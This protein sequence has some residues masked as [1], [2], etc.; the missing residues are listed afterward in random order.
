MRFRGGVS[1]GVLEGSGLRVYIT[2][3]IWSIRFKFRVPF[4]GC[5]FQ[6][7]KFRVQASGF[8]VQ[9]SRFQSGCYNTDPETLHNSS[10]CDREQ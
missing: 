4:S 10:R 9:C 3:S 1:G 6:A 8:R 5:R 7:L 2:E